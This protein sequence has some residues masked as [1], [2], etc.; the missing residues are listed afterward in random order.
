MATRSNRRA[1]RRTNHRRP[2]WSLLTTLKGSA[3][4]RWRET[5][6]LLHAVS[7]TPPVAKV[8]IS[9]TLLLLLFLTVN[10]VYHAVTKPSEVFFPLDQSLGKNLTQSWEEYGPLF[11]EHA[12]TVITPELLAALAQ[13][14]SNGNPVART[15]WRWQW[16]WNPFMWYQPASSAVGMYQLTDATF[17]AAK[18]YCIHDHH[19]TED[20]PW[21]DPHSCWFN[22]LYTRVI[23]S[24]AIEMTAALLDRRIA[25][26][27]AGRPQATLTQKHNLA[28][29]IHLCGAG[30]GHQFALRRFRLTPHQRCGEHDVRTYLTRVEL[31]KQRFIKLNTAG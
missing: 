3:H 11:R 23:P 15:Y 26:E 30:A 22:S 19:V 29:V 10:W 6:T 8:L 13:V 5:H 20:G 14:E 28:A 1:Q 4:R 17:Q 27:L 18:R 31:L 9:T 21:H 24:H 16:S 12:T 25:L 7:K 2:P